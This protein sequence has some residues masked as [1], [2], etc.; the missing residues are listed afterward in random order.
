MLSA[1]MI[2]PTYYSKKIP[3]IRIS[4]EHEYTKLAMVRQSTSEKCLYKNV[5]S[6]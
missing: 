3:T 6:K 2:D 5:A 1:I 4:N